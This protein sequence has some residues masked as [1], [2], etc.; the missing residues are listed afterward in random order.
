MGNIMESQEKGKKTDFIKRITD[1][2]RKER[3]K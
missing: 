3:T 2:A 1:I